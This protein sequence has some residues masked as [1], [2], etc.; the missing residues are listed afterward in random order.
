MV[1]RGM[2]NGVFC[3]VSFFLPHRHSMGCMV[4]SYGNTSGKHEASFSCS[5]VSLQGTTTTTQAVPLFSQSHVPTYDPTFYTRHSLCSAIHVEDYDYHS[6]QS[7][8]HH[9]LRS[10]MS[11]TIR[12]VHV[13][14]THLFT[15]NFVF[16]LL[17]YTLPISL[18]LATSVFI[19][20]YITMRS[21]MDGIHVTTT[22]NEGGYR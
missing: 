13:A 14:M 22:T 5:F 21:W 4:T 6:R 3:V 12:G 1:V 18:Y 7:V 9:A 19:V 8:R 10:P 17:Q 16:F 20:I 11:T 2:S 15:T